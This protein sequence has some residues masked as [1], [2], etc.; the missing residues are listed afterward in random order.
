MLQYLS[1]TQR[2]WIYS[3]NVTERYGNS[4]LSRFF[5]NK[6]SAESLGVDLDHLYPT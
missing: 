6:R 1:D 4:S 2:L 5:P 3:F